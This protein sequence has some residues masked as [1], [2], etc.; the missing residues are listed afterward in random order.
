MMPYER[1]SK[2]WPSYRWPNYNHIC[3]LLFYPEH[4]EQFKQAS[5]N[6]AQYVGLAKKEELGGRK[7]NVK[8]KLNDYGDLLSNKVKGIDKNLENKNGNRDEKKL[9]TPAPDVAKV[10]T[11]S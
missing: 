6:L 10:E 9:A 5:K 8:D 3:Y 11:K 2:N 7:I 4:I 1:F